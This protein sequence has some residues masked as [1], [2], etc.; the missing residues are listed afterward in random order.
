MYISKYKHSRPH[1]KNFLESVSGIAT[2]IIEDIKD[3]GNK[4]RIHAQLD[5]LQEEIEKSWEPERS[6][7]RDEYNSLKREM[8]RESKLQ[9]ISNSQSKELLE[10]FPNIST[11]PASKLLKIDKNE[12]ERGKLL[13]S[14]FLY[15]INKD[16]D[17]FIKYDPLEDVK[18][19][20]IGKEFFV[21]FGTNRS[22][23]NRIWLW[24][25]LPASIE[26]IKV[27]N[28]VWVRAN[29]WNRAWYYDAPNP[30]G[31]IPVFNG[32]TITIPNQKEID[33][34]NSS[35][36]DI[37]EYSDTSEDDAKWVTDDYVDFLDRTQDT[38]IEINTVSRESYNF[39]IKS[40]F[41]HEQ[42]CWLLANEF[43]ES[44]FDARARGDSGKAHWIF[45]WHQDRRNNIMKW[46]WINISSANHLDQLKWA[47]WEMQHWR[48]NAAYQAL[49]NTKTAHE[50][51]NIFCKLYERPSNKELR[52]MERWRTATS[53]SERMLANSGNE[54]ASPLPNLKI[55][56]PIALIGRDREIIEDQLATIR[57]L[58]ARTT[59]HQAIVPALRKVE[60]EI[61]SDTDARSYKIDRVD[62]YNYRNMR[63]SNKLSMHALGI[64]IDIN[65]QNNQGSFWNG[66]K[67]I[68]NSV[69]NIMKRNWFIW[70][71][72][73]KAPRNDPMHFEYSN[74]E[75][76]AKA[77]R[78]DK[79]MI[80]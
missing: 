7:L 70:W 26:Y 3:L 14:M 48:E 49:K 19:F 52:W 18:N 53:Y 44:G 8:N 2:E 71:W 67:N 76:L 66:S 33:E 35:K 79:S 34:F 74:N 56:N 50:A 25:M 1:Y 21:D 28:K 36:K 42:A 69:V 62:G 41:T 29:I 55:G 22:A 17:W 31:Y 39:W 30:Q 5:K 47:L 64:A 9:R 38:S 51:G 65:P 40:G 78:L 46:T 58:G 72:D 13:S 57:F 43:H 80:A 45:Q 12:W 6:K 32:N 68:P 73:W 75:L 63:N 16:S 54:K 27:G 23:N 77:I 59:V 61:L 15:S 20:Q 10:K 24:H 60:R 4:D 11:I 37:S